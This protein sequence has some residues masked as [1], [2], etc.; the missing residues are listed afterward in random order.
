MTTARTSLELPRVSECEDRDA[1]TFAS[2]RFDLAS[3]A[4]Q[5]FYRLFDEGNLAALQHRN[6]VA[7][8]MMRDAALV[9]EQADIP[10]L[11]AQA[12]RG[13]SLMLSRGGEHEEAKAFAQAA[14]TQAERAGDPDD[15]VLGWHRLGHAAHIARREE[16]AAFH[17]AR[18]LT[19]ADGFD[20]DLRGPGRRSGNCSPCGAPQ[21]RPRSG[22]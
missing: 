11:A 3:P 14:L 22:R 18:A 8:L 9:A 10:K 20:A 19:I 6:G 7:E 15:V 16:D 2:G 4:V 13:V 12:L 21:G 5:E 17:L 1:L